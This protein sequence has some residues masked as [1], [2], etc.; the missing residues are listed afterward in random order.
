MASPD[1]LN[2]A[3]LLAGVSI[4]NPQGISNPDAAP[5]DQV[6]N[7]ATLDAAPPADPVA[8][9]R[10]FPPSVTATLQRRVG[11]SPDSIMIVAFPWLAPAHIQ[12]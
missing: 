7:A 1:Q 12:P 2:R 9:F 11:E 5:E 4:G 10:L 6:S 8:L 3:F